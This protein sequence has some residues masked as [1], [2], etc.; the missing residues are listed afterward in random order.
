MRRGL[1]IYQ[2]PPAC[3]V[4]APRTTQ[5]TVNQENTQGH[6]QR[7]PMEQPHHPHR[8]CKRTLKPIPTSQKPDKQWVNTKNLSATLLTTGNQS[9]RTQT[10]PAL[11]VQ[12]PLKANPATPVPTPN[13][14][15]CITC[16]STP[17]PAYRQEDQNEGTSSL[18][19][20]KYLRYV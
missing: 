20:Y 16:T 18:T 7:A 6:P 13:A 12:P 11:V 17:N 5:H 19:I 15:K 2:S 1:I 8:K 14:P 9:P 4:K 10:P 3:W